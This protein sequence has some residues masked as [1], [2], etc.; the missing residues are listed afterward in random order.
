M[1]SVPLLKKCAS[2]RRR[3]DW[4]ARKADWPK[5]RAHEVRQ[6]SPK[7][8]SVPSRSIASIEPTGDYSVI[9]PIG[10]REAPAANLQLTARAKRSQCSDS[11]HHSNPP[12]CWRLTGIRGPLESEDNNDEYSGV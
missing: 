4:T 11:V 9:V 1:S 8:I 12:P 7:F 5:R 10:L 3:R 2:A 6:R